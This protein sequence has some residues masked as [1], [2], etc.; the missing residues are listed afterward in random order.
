MDI[1]ITVSDTLR[2]K[3]L[4]SDRVVV[5]ARKGHPAIGRE[6]DLDTYLRQDHILVSSR[7]LG[8]SLVDAELNRKGRKRS[9]VLRCQHYF[10][11][12]RVVDE[13]DMLL[14]IPDHYA[15]M[16]NTGFNHRLYPFP[17]KSLQQLEIHM[18][19]H[20]SA[21][22]DPPNRWLREQIKKVVDETFSEAEPELRGRTRSSERNRS[23]PQL[24][25]RN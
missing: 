8:P 6:L 3:P 21:E 4:F 17:L 18:Y 20:E 9:I 16:L 13:T 15:Q 11:A 10:A 22:N 23:K 5:M 25:R 24:S 12:C 2:Q 14:T 19:W 7:R 1:P